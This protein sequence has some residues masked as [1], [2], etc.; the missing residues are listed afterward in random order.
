MLFQ[1]PVQV[2]VVLVV[3]VVVLVGLPLVRALLCAVSIATLSHEG[4]AS[5]VLVVLITRTLSL[6]MC[7]HQG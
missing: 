2:V 7:Y 5:S 3:L 6:Y 4:H 1:G